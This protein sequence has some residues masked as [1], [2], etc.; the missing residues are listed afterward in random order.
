[1]SCPAV[2]PRKPPQAPCSSQ[3]ATLEIGS[4]LGPGIPP[5]AKRIKGTKA[6]PAVEPTQ[7]TKFRGGSGHGARSG[8]DAA[9]R[10]SNL[11]FGEGLP[12]EGVARE[13][14]IGNHAED[15]VI[16]KLGERNLFLQLGRSLPHPGRRY[17]PNAVVED[18][19][20]AYPH[21]HARL[22]VVPR[23][24]YDANTVDNVGTKPE[25]SFAN[26]LT[27][28][29]PRRLEQAVALAGARGVVTNDA[30]LEKGVN[31][32]NQLR[33]AVDTSRELEEPRVNWQADWA[34]WKAVGGQRNTRP[35]RPPFPFAIT[36]GCSCKA[37]HIKIDTHALHGLLR[38]TGMLPANVTLEEKFGS[39]VVRRG[40]KLGPKDSEPNLAAVRPNV[41]QIFGQMVHTDEV[42]NNVMFTRPKPAEPSGEQPCM[43][44]EEG[45]VDPP[46]HLDSDWLG[47]DPRKTNSASVAH[48]ERYP[49]GAEK[50]VWQRSL[51]AGQHY[52]QS[53]M[54]ENAKD[55]LGK[56]GQEACAA[57]LV[58]QEL[59][60]GR[61]LSCKPC[62]VVPRKP[63]QAPCSSQA[64]TQ[65]IG[66][67]LGPGIPPPAKRIKGTKAEPAVEP[68]QPTKFRG[69]S[70]HGARSGRDAASRKSNLCFGE[71]L[72]YEGVARE[73]AIGNHAEDAVIPK[74]GERNLFL[75]LGRS[76]PH[77]GRRY[78]PNA[79]VEDVMAA[80]PHLHARLNVVPRYEYDAN[81]VDNVGTKPESSF[82]NCLT[83]L[84]PRRLEQA[85][86][87][88]G[89][90][91]V[92]TNDAWLE[93]GVN[94]GNQLRNAV[95]TSR[96]LE[97]PRVNWQADW[98]DWKAVGG[99]RNTRPFRPPFPFAI[100]PGCSCKAHHIKIDTHAL[101]GLL[102]TTGMLP[103]N[104]T[105]EEKFGSGVVRRGRKL[106]PKDSEPNL[107]A[108]RPNVGQIFGQMVHTDEVANNVMFTRPKP[109]E[110]SGEQPC[111]GKEE[112][113]VDP[114]AHLDSDWL[115]CDPRKT[116]SASVA[117]EE[118][119][120]SG[121]EKSVWQRS[122]IAG[123]HYR[124]SGMT[125]NA[126]YWPNQEALPAEGKE[127]PGL[128]YKRLR[129][130]P[131]K[132]Q[133]QQPK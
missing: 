5:P 72:P 15:A 30:W 28:L 20:A 22:N 36:P 61:F 100:T 87:L 50:S 10:K 106:G 24:E 66:S 131:P 49:S 76:L 81:T 48:E 125:E 89:A 59:S 98:A 115:G 84:F 105:L 132:D 47:C 107:A 41:G 111:M 85:V 9:S 90:R 16:P 62:V 13:L 102:R 83:E 40:R 114:P 123:Q 1:M 3:A 34:D 79:V 45:V 12:Y 110:P 4:E 18:V 8:R 82:A 68:T 65:E 99:Q 26:C 7:P 57:R 71:G 54:T 130:K 29:F 44:K 37:H 80:Y 19:M 33:N 31:W 126:K 103:A 63:P 96:E 60:L 97:E 109:A 32:G 46:A 25:S 42:A 116:N 104:V 17:R 35:F 70:G 38:T 128:G 74:L 39:G 67:E 112:G 133:Q 93:K 43:G 21:L 86:A 129:N 55:A 2:V 119:Y 108:V 113:V 94:W 122:L 51:I 124:Q 120:P 101:H 58:S 11:C 95:D 14:A 92:V 117:H 53:G 6:E 64:A 56:A 78:R 88:A 75:Q 27:E 52:R 69:G 118:R 23:Y 127:Y 121:A 91:G 73:L 77:P